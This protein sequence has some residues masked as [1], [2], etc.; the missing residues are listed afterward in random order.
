[1]GPKYFWK[2]HSTSNRMPIDLK[3]YQLF[4]LFG[5][6]PILPDIKAELKKYVECPD[7]LPIHQLENIQCY[8]PRELDNVAILNYN[9][10]S[11]GHS[12]KFKRDPITGKIG[13]MLEV[14][15][16]S[17]GETARNSMSMMRAP[18]PS[19]EGV[20]GNTS[21][22]L[23]WPGGFDE[24]EE[25][26]R[27][28]MSDV[29]FE[30]NLRTLAKGF[31][32]GIEFQSDNCSPK[33]IQVGEFFHV[34]SK[35]EYK[36]ETDTVNLIDIVNEESNLLKLWSKTVSET[37]SKE[38]YVQEHDI[39]LHVIDEITEPSTESEIPF[40]KISEHTKTYSQ[41]EWAEQLDVSVA[42]SDFDKKVP[43]PAIKFKY[44][45]D[46]FQK[47][48]IIKLEE[49]CNVFV[50]A[51]TSAG[52]TTVAE[53]AIALSQ[54]HKTRSIYT[55]PIKALSN[56]KFREF[57]EKFNDVGLITGDLQINQ[58]ATCLIMTT[59]ILQ[60]MLYCA[61]EVLRDLEYVI[62]DE[63]HY[64]NNEDR[65]HVWEEI[66]ILLPST[67]N[68]V[69]L[70]ATVPNP[71]KFANWVGQIKKRKMYVISTV[72]RPVPLQHYLY[73]GSNMKT[74]DSNYLLLDTDGK[75]SIEA[76]RR[77][78]A[79]REFELK[80]SLEKKGT[81][82]FKE[83][84]KQNKV[85]LEPVG[86]F[87]EPEPP[88]EKRP[89]MISQK[90][91]AMWVAFLKYLQQ[92]D[93]LPVVV[94][95]LSRNRCDKT[96]ESLQ[97]Q[98]VELITSSQ[99]DNVKSF[100]KKSI[101]RLK[102]SDAQLPQVL[103]IEKLLEHGIGIHHSGILPILKEIVELLFQMGLVKM[104]FATETFAMGVNMPAR[105]VV[106]D[107]V[108][109]YDGSKF[110][111]LYPTEYIQ[112]AGRAGRRGHDTTGTVI[113]VCKTEVPNFI[114][115][116]AMMCGEPQSLESQ[117]KI[118]YSMV[119]HLRR[120]SETVSV[121]DMMR[122]S[123]KEASSLVKEKQMKAALEKIEESLAKSPTLSLCQQEL[124]EFYE[125][126]IEYLRIWS[127][128]RP[129]MLSTKR[130]VKNLVEGRVL[131]VSFQFHYNKLAVLLD[132]G[133]R[134]QNVTYK[135]LLL[136]NEEEKSTEKNDNWYKIIALTKEKLFLPNHVPSH[137]VLII[138][139]HNILEITNCTIKADY[140]FV[141]ADWERRQIPR[142]RDSPPGPATNTVVQELLRLSLE[143]TK[144]F[145]VLLPFTEMV[146]NGIDLKPKE[147]KLKDLKQKMRSFAMTQAEN[148]EEHFKEAFFRK[149]L[150]EK[151]KEL[152]IK[153]SDNNLRDYPDYESRVN[154][155]KILGYIDQDERVTLKGRVALEMGT[156]ELFLTELVFKNILTDWS[157][158]EIAALLSSLVFQ[159]RT[160]VTNDDLSPRMKE[161]QNVVAQE[162][163]DLEK[164]ERQYSV[165]PASPLSFGLVN[166][167]YQWAKAESFGNIM[168]LTDVQEGIIVRCIQQLNET[169]RDVKNAAI[170]I[171]NPI[172]KEKMEEASTAIKRDIVFTAS[173]YTQ[174]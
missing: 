145:K 32:S 47:Q 87:Q 141:K 129:H 4:M 64:I 147:Q 11:V 113:I 105:T 56:Q 139:D 36:E 6:P 85:A 68:I 43:D 70:S 166:V 104:L 168:K 28:L 53:Y 62:F 130:A 155:L 156:H 118:T 148:F 2:K 126:A 44:E 21:N 163:E 150:E 29:Y 39:S 23:F 84:K 144:N 110:R 9:L 132:M 142:F 19:A 159:Q 100:F 96:A 71:L 75:F 154:I 121:K 143:A 65:G 157:P 167:V 106:F 14:D 95:A 115:L 77:A 24:P 116:Q 59:E 117:F 26:E 91:R 34:E 136:T 60:S 15:L 127:S 138:E 79:Q 78:H 170:I 97:H 33:I 63:V 57:K 109:K 49:D 82:K 137:E 22:F 74:K 161:L 114:D 16:R 149:E 151:R 67:V 99:K 17:T 31:K 164:M 50:A 172:L 40:L 133:R 13:E 81:K 122:R 1:M 146:I 35:E 125:T 102:G 140:A 46:N 158:P 72:K 165:I 119:L 76:W 38:K 61:S 162:F 123:F 66:V 112:M 45:L 93:K 58:N 25:P 103:K 124:G 160:E 52:K 98:N 89:S 8:W 18:G 108:V 92:Q 5:P 94:F 152:M 27:T 83:S 41:A 51:H 42:V 135:V 173:L 20:R 88:E 7:K 153:L 37:K 86:A 101:K 131:L 30:S 80:Q 73:V 12:L 120:L 3:G 54:R 107:A 171:G 69:M 174:D 134:A 55:S 48:A 90:E 169:L 111:H 128:F 10:A